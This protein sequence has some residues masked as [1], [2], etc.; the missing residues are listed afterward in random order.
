MQHLEIF[1]VG[2]FAW[3]ILC[4]CGLAAAF[5][6]RRPTPHVPAARKGATIYPALALKACGFAAVWSVRRQLFTHIVDL[7]AALEITLAVI[8]VA[9]ATTSV[10]FAGMA[11]RELGR[12]WSVEARTVA[13]HELVTTGPYAIVRHPIYTGLFGML[14]ATGLALSTAAGLGAGV[15]LYLAGAAL[16]IR[17]EDRLLRSAFG[18]AYDDYAAR[19]PAFL[20]RP[21]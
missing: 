9:I 20:P 19:V 12:H 17:A 5:L 14:V 4:W 7:P 10:L 2:V 11:V 15:V 21:W 16:R 18:G 13:D 3:V 6:L 8:T 1:H